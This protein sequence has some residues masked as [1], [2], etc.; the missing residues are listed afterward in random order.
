MR[1]QFKYLILLFAMFAVVKA[2]DDKPIDCDEIA[3]KIIGKNVMDA[4]DTNSHP[5]NDDSRDSQ[6]LMVSRFYKS[7]AMDV[8]SKLSTG[9]F[10][11]G[12]AFMAGSAIDYLYTNADLLA[13][14][15]SIGTSIMVNSLIM[16]NYLI[17]SSSI[18][19][20]AKLMIPAGLSCFAFKYLIDTKVLR[21]FG[22]SGVE[23]G[24]E[25]EE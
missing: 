8:S 22:E 17:S 9:L 19:E 5:L 2:A 24:N 16:A 1:F 10:Y 6:K 7:L 25:K 21:Y 14:V 20:Y 18:P 13:D 11:A 23:P 3:V 12:T 4:K 15:F